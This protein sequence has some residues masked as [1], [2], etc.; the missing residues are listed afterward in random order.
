[1]DLQG[2]LLHQA[3]KSTYRIM[4]LMKRFR[5]DKTLGVENRSFLSVVGMRARLTRKGQDKGILKVMELF[6]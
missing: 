5:K 4:P 1:M 3:Q 6:L 2:G